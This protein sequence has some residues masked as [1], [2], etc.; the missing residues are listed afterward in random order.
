MNTPR[1]YHFDNPLPTPTES[2]P[3]A[4][5]PY[6]PQPQ[7]STE[8]PSAYGQAAPV[9][10]QHIHQAPPDR[11]VQRLALGSGMGAGAVA[12]G[13][14][15]GPLLVAA[16]SSMAIS[17]A[18]VALVVV[19]VVWGLTTVVKSVGGQDGKAAAQSLSKTRRR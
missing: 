2:T 16:I 10:I 1:R 5:V 4:P 12:A 13:V 9:V 7:S 17:L 3:A 14:Y 19:A 6:M 15:F 18:V 11:T 8:Q